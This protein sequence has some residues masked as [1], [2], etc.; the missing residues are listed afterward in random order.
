MTDIDALSRRVPNICRV[1]PAT[2]KYHVEDVHRAG[3]VMGILGE[4]DRAGVI[5]AT[6]AT[7]HSETLGAAL[8]QWDICRDSSAED[9]RTFFKSGP[10]GRST[11]QAFSQ[12]TRW[13]TL[14]LD[15]SGGCIRSVEHAYSKDGGLAVLHGN[16]AT[17]GCIAKTAGVDEEMLTFVGPARV[18]EGQDEAVAGIL[19]GE[20]EAGEVVVVRYEGPKGGPGMQEMLYLTTYIKSIGLGRACALLT[21]GRFS[22][23]TS[24]LAVGHVSP[25]AAE[26]G[27][28]ALVR[29]G[30]LIAI[31]IPRRTIV[32]Q[33]DDVTLQRRRDDEEGRGASAWTPRE[34]VRSVSEALRAYAALTTSAARGAVRDVG[35]IS[36]R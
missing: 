5:D 3:G 20:V 4:L 28:I 34:R 29:V 16:V 19:G 10:A 2:E 33:V 11:Q 35:Q 14:D 25:E 26:G 23:G 18:Y 9:V 1:A 13:A 6:V 8:D 12:A 36:R 21:D 31:D 32:L 27:L 17:E 15:R 24:G 22:G 30:D 7:V